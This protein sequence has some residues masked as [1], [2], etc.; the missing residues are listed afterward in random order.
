MVKIVTA[1]TV[2]ITDTT[3]LKRNF[4]KSKDK[5]PEVTCLKRAPNFSMR[6]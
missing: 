3:L 6:E 4:L 5:I 1:K 2:K